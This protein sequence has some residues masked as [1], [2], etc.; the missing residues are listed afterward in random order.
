MC[1][2]F[3]S[4]VLVC[5]KRWFKIT[6][7]TQVLIQLYIFPINEKINTFICTYMAFRNDFLFFSD[8]HLQNISKNFEQLVLN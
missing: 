5:F 7:L 1:V 8:F 6:L 3:I 4:Y 2:V